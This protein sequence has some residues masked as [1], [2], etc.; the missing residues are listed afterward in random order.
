MSL[1]Q[2]VPKERLLNIYK[3]DDL[4]Y[5]AIRKLLRLSS[6]DLSK[7]LNIQPDSIRF[8]E[9]IGDSTRILFLELANLLEISMTYYKDINKLNAWLFT[10]N[11]TLKNI[12][13]TDFIRNGNHKTL[14]LIL[15]DQMDA[16]V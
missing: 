12:T 5:A 7:I 6:Y 1:F 3:G 2:T 4:D 14:L 8:D 15:I 16:V 13:P 10:P 9:R 11:P